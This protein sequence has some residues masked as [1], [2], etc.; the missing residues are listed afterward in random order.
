MSTPDPTLG[1]QI[2][3]NAAQRIAK[4]MEDAMLEEDV[5]CWVNTLAEEIDEAF[6]RE[7]G[8]AIEMAK[9]DPR[10]TQ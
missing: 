4:V 7:C 3:C 10:F 6:Q 1:Q 9:S 5:L 8:R 2:A